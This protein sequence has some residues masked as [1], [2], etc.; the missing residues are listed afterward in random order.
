MLSSLTSTIPSS[1][2]YA[3]HSD[4]I[5]PNCRESMRTVDERNI[6]IID[7]QMAQ[8]LKDKSPQQRLFIAFSMW[9]EAKKQL[10]H[11][12]FSLHPDWDENKIQREVAKRL[13]HGI[14]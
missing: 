9:S 4:G 7:N 12:L 3:D 6:E 13:S 11:Y 10:T 14:A 2:F 8:V 1:I 5:N